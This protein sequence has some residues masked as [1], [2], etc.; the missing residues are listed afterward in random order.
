[1]K[2]KLLILS[3]KDVQD[4]VRTALKPEQVVKC[5]ARVFEMV[6]GSEIGAGVVSA[7]HLLTPSNN[8]LCYGIHTASIKCSIQIQY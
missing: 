5:M 7:K 3:D 6:S 4:L 8:I 2:S 1:M